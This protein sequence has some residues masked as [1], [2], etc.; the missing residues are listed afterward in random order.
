MSAVKAVGKIISSSPRQFSR[1]IIYW[2]FQTKKWKDSFLNAYFKAI[3][4]YLVQELF[5]VLFYL[6]SAT[7]R[8]GIVLPSFRGPFDIQKRQNIRKI[9]KL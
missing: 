7:K 6:G 4:L 3:Q 2:E 5:C 8:G 9:S 1:N